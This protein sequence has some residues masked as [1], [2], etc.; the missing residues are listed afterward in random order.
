MQELLKCLS[1]AFVLLQ[2]H[3]GNAVALIPLFD[4]VDQVA[5]DRIGPQHA[6]LVAFVLEELLQL[7]AEMAFPLPVVVNRMV[8]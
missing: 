3:H 7:S 6:R 5:H 1:D 8:R 4:A 2:D